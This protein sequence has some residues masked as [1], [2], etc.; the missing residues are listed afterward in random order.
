MRE[1]EAVNELVFKWSYTGYQNTKYAEWLALLWSM[2]GA[3]LYPYSLSFLFVMQGVI[4]L[5]L[6]HCLFQCI[7]KGT[8]GCDIHSQCST[9]FTYSACDLI[10]MLTVIEVDSCWAGWAQQLLCYVMLC[11]GRLI[12][13]SFELYFNTGKSNHEVMAVLRLWIKSHVFKLCRF[14]VS[15]LLQETPYSETGTLRYLQT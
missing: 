5:L 3:F 11:M 14:V 9:V 1:K 4:F 7:F 6:S 15:W 12:K 13:H 8:N 2:N 10:S